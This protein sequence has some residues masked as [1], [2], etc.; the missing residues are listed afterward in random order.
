MHHLQFSEVTPKDLQGGQ[1]KSL[2][3]LGGATRAE[4]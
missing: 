4:D 2:M 1:H 3:K